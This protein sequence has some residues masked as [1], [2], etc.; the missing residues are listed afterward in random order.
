MELDIL[1]IG[2][3]PDDSEIGCGGLLL[4]MKSLGYRTGVIHLT[5]GEMGSRGDGKIRAREID[6][7][8]K[9]LELDHVEALDF[10]DCQVTD[11]FQSRLKVAEA[12][13]RVKPKMVLCPYW[14]TPPGRGLGHTDHIA[15]GNLVLHA[16][17][18]AHLAKLPIEGAPHEVRAVFHYFLPLDVSP[19]FVVDVT[20]HFKGWMDSV[21][22]HRSQFYN[23][24]TKKYE[25]LHFIEGMARHFGRMIRV[26]YGAGFL[27]GG[28]LPV[29]DPFVLLKR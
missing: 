19:T 5:L 24:R 13:R 3:H 1:A 4:K 2:A 14:G 11:D 9:V 6:R 29:T 17:N 25:A 12:L 15:C 7:A 27:A 28:P 16:A 18:F 20:D 23:P 8:A 21:K 22:A 10:K 26:R